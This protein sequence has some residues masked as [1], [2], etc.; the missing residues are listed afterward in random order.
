[1]N[2]YKKPVL[3]VDCDGVLS[4][5]SHLFKSLNKVLKTNLKFEDC[6]KYHLHKIWNI[7][8]E[9]MDKALNEIESFFSFEDSNPVEF[10][11]EAINI[12]CGL[13]EIKVLTARRPAHEELTKRWL[14]KYFGDIE[15]IFARSN[16][17]LY[18][19]K[20]EKS[21]IDICLRENAFALIEDN[22]H[23]LQDLTKLAPKVR[24]VCLELPYNGQLKKQKNIFVGDW[25]EIVDYLLT[26]R[27][28][29]LSK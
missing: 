27:A 7:S 29:D 19:N 20:A 26:E 25:R 14:K 1:M 23:E 28:K 22:P 9:E 11:R 13:F 10:S 6:K 21:K 4:D 12:L 2:N 18:G 17:N 16:S 15:V 8:L 3:L 5:L 24:A